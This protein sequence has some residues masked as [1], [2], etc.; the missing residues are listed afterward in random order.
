VGASVLAIFLGREAFRFV[1][2]G[3]LGIIPRNYHDYSGNRRLCQMGVL[4]QWSDNRQWPIRDM[5]WR[6]RES[7]YRRAKR[8]DQSH[9]YWCGL[10]DWVLYLLEGPVLEKQV[11]EAKERR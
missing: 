7:E 8:G 11:E 9:G 4:L 1:E 5:F 3:D 6:Q 2:R 10:I